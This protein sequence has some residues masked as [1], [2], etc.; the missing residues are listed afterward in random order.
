MAEKKHASTQY[1]PLG[2]TS[3]DIVLL[4]ILIVLLA[5]GLIL[6]RRLKQESL[7]SSR[8]TPTPS[9]L[10]E[11]ASTQA[12]AAGETP[13]GALTEP[14]SQSQTEAPTRRP[15]YTR[16]PATETPTRI[17]TDAG[18]SPATEL[19]TSAPTDTPAPV[20][21]PS[22]EAL[23]GLIVFPVFDP[24]AGTYN[25]YC[26]KP[27]GRDR[28]LVVEEASQPTLNSTGDRIAYRSWAQNR[29]LFERGIDG[30]DGWKFD[31]YGEA[32][33]PAFSPDDQTFL[34]QSRE[35]GEKFAIYRTV[36]TEYKVLRREAFPV[37]GEAPAWTRDGVSL[38]YKGCLGDLC[39]LYKINIDGSSPQQLTED[40]SDTNPAVSPD[41][42]TIAFMSGS[43]R[44]WDIYIMRID[45]SGRKPLTDDPDADGLPTW[46]PD[47]K[48]IAFVSTRSG[49]WAM[50]AMDAD[51]GNQRLLFELGGSI[52]G[53]VQVD[54][55]NSHGWLEESIDWAP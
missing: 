19:V 22:P 12:I 28:R 35:G 46:S 54:V 13:T 44:N 1:G 38:V 21:P 51:G 2:L 47:G 26:A 30:S 18:T 27:D 45:G 25:I 17:P 52:D 37:E 53:A 3:R 49:Q 34:F 14:A 11:A 42:R 7:A 20:Q 4:V 6:G 40:L 50:W 43:D 39:G 36:G 41:G 15:T 55:Q 16:R 32:A 29:G 9:V 33:R 10:P 5:L 48:T 24:A 8:P 31:P 23:T